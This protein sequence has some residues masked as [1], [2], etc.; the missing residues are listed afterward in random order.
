[1]RSLN[2]LVL[3]LIVV[4]SCVSGPVAAQPG[5]CSCAPEVP[6]AK[7]LVS[8][9]CAKIWS[10]KAC[11]LKE[12]AVA[13]A[14]PAQLERWLQRVY[15]QVPEPHHRL[16]P[17]KWPFVLENS[18]ESVEFQREISTVGTAESLQ[19]LERLVLVS[20]AD[21]VRESFAAAVVNVLRRRSTE[22]RVGWR[23]DRSV[24]NDPAIPLQVIVDSRCLYAR[25]GDENFYVNASGGSCRAAASGAR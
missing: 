3:V 11:T 15:S 20:I 17:G 10:N 7:A 1:M 21:G 24:L 4:L 19:S 13:G 18:A 25:L 22:V 5:E 9:T 16:S 14:Q 12:S 8:S 6:N 23:G 2:P